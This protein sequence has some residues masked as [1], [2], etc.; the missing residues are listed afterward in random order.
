[1]FTYTYTLTGAAAESGGGSATVSGAAFSAVRQTG[2]GE[3]DAYSPD[4]AAL[5]LRWVNNGTAYTT[6]KQALTDSA[7]YVPL[8]VPQLGLDAQPAAARAGAFLNVTAVLPAAPFARALQI[9]AQG[10]QS[11][12]PLSVSLSAT[13]ADGAF[14]ALTQTLRYTS[15]GELTLRLVFMACGAAVRVA[16]PDYAR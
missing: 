9:T 13:V 4:G 11:E 5:W 6:A 15:G 3:M 2:A 8:F 12:T 16:A 14:A 1:M 10:R 7:A